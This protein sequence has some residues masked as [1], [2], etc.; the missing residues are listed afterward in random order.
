MVNAGTEGRDWWIKGDIVDQEARVDL[1]M[2]LRRTRMG[3]T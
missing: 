1:K 2:S 3:G